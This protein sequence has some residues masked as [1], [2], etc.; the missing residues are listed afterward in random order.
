[1]TTQIRSELQNRIV[2]AAVLICA[3]LGL[4]LLAA[5]TSFGR[6]ALL[7]AVFVLLGLCAFEVA[8]LLG[9]EAGNESPDPILGALV[10]LCTVLPVLVIYLLNAGMH[11]L[12]TG[13]FALLILSCLPA[14]CLQVVVGRKELEVAKGLAATLFP[15]LFLVGICGSALLSLAGAERGYAYGIWLVS[16]VA[17]ND[18][19]AYFLGKQIGG[20]KLAPAISPNKTISGSLA[21]IAVGTVAGVCLW[22]LLIRNTDNLYAAA[23]FSSLVTLSAQIGDLIKSYIKRVKNVKD[24]GNILPGHGGILDRLDGFIAG[25]AALYGIL[26]GLLGL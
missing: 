4:I 24:T 11:N 21:G 25:G 19:A 12:N 18:S 20:P 9:R 6:Y 1:M 17:L 2:T 8:R 5:Y 22:A 10:F 14:L 15:G 3:L 23:F 7:S 26:F 13:S 16:V